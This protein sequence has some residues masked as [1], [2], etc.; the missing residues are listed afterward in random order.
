MV[1]KK[2][3]EKKSDVRTKIMNST[4]YKI[5]GLD[6]VINRFVYYIY[7]YYIHVKFL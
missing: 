1:L 3:F 5:L 2:D 4:D 6:Q 7:L